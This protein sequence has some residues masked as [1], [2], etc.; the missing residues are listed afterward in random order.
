MT[1]VTVDPKT[2]WE[3]LGSVQWFYRC[4]DGKF[5]VLQAVWTDKLG[6]FPWEEGHDQ[7][8][9]KIQPL[10]THAHR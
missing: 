8:A 1:F 5:P 6:K 7:H 10:L 9:A 3:F 4:L 2:Y